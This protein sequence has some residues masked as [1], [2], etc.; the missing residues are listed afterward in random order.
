MAEKRSLTVVP[1][2]AG[3]A[4]PS[5]M[6]RRDVIRALV[7]S[8]GAG[9]ALPAVAESHPMHRH[10][11][12]AS[13]LAEADAA[14]TAKTWKPAFLDA[15]QSET[16]GSLAEQIVPGSNAAGVH[17][18]VDLLLSVDTQENQRKF[19]TA[20]GAIEGAAIERYRK[21]WKALTS[22]QQVELLTAVSTAA[23]GARDESGAG[24]VTV[25][26]HFDNLK[27]WASGAY[28]SSEPG[29]RELGWTGNVF[30]EGFPGCT[31]PDGHR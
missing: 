27:G 31:H 6:A 20:L 30:H 29:M 14:A 16:F 21:P 12:D 13:A 26:D 7:G 22:A 10:L 15:H 11:T 18:F 25:R 2:A 4:T 8:V 28:Y 5:G 3:S 1:A 23:A 24:H 17:R 9:L 19:L